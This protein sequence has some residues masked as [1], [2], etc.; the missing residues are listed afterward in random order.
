MAGHSSMSPATEEDLLHIGSHTVKRW[1]GTNNVKVKISEKT[2]SSVFLKIKI[3]LQGAWRKEGAHSYQHLIQRRNSHSLVTISLFSITGHQ[4]LVT[5][6]FSVIPI[7]VSFI[8]VDLGRQEGWFGPTD[9]QSQKNP[10]SA[11]A[12]LTGKFL[13]IRKV[14]ATSSLL[15]KEFPVNLENVW[16]LNNISR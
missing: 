11:S 9:G 1:R 6:I 12:M 13:R 15:A 8:P 7:I 2:C 4:N 5:Y 10:V 14:F 3:I 16:I